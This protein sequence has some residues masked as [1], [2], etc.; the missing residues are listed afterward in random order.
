MEKLM[1]PEEAARLLAVSPR[2]V[3][4]WLRRGDLKGVKAGNL[5]RIRESDLERF[6]GEDEDR[7]RREPLDPFSPGRM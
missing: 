2:T 5:W 6:L 3:K 7:T 1:T 4:D